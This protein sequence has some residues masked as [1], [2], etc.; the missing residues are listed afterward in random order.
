MPDNIT[1]ASV[2]IATKADIARL[3]EQ[4]KGLDRAIETRFAGIERLQAERSIALRDVLTASQRA[5]DKAEM[6]QHNV[7]IASNEFRKSLEDLSKHQASRPELDSLDKRVQALERGA[8]GGLGRQ[9]AFMTAKGDILAII[10]LLVAL[11]SMAM[12]YFI[13]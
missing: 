12:K 11:A 10:A 13:R 7:N 3:E 8:A 5:A 2:Y 1:Q 9:G 6:A 4:V